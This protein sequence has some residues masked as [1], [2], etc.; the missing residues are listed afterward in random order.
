MRE[1]GTTRA[2]GRRAQWWCWALAHILLL[3]LIATLATRFLDTDGTVQDTV[4]VQSG[5]SRA[6]RQHMDRDAVR[7]AAPVLQLA[8]R[9]AP[10]FCPRVAPTGALRPTLFLE[11]NLFNRPPPAC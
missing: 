8:L 11:E 10:T 6:M 7:W 2:E 3:S 9:Q 4:T 5:S 1:V